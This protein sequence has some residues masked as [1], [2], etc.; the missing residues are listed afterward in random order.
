MVK[1]NPN[2]ILG[3]CM[4]K[5]LLLPRLQDRFISLI[6]F[7]LEHNRVKQEELASF[8]GI[9]PS[10]LSNLLHKKR[11]L[12][13]TYILTFIVKGVIM[14]NE[15]HDGRALTETEREFWETVDA[16]QRIGLLHK[17]VAAEKL[18][19]NVE[20]LLDSYIKTQGKK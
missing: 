13:A 14:A 17:V 18:G 9:P 19:L 5:R 4:F 11:T 7:Y 10:H 15:L 16:F 1:S 2:L 8:V 20:A 6:T 12:S 3:G